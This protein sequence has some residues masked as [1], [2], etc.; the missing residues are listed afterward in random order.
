MDIKELKAGKSILEV[1][2]HPWELARFTVVY[3]IIRKQISVNNLENIV[4]L[5]CGDTFFLEKL[6]QKIPDGTFHGI[7]IAFDDELL[8]FLSEKLKDKNIFLY[9]NYQSLAEKKIVADLILLLDVIEHIKDD[10][11]FMSELRDNTIINEDTRILI[12]VPAFESLSTSRDKWLGHFRRYTAGTLTNM[13]NRAGFEVL[14]K[15]YFFSSLVFPRYLQ[16]IS[17]K[18]RKPMEEAISGIGNYRA[19]PFIDPLMKNVM[20]FDYKLTRLLSS[21]GIHVPGLSCFAICK[22]K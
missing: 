6:Q 21:L 14:R 2:H 17:E 20:I 18:A 10:L 3:D 7:D 12:T 22:R 15:G 4:D 5:G 8:T 13:L 9:S 1:D 11:Q 19:K 16:K